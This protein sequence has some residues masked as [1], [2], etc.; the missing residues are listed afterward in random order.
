VVVESDIAPEVAFGG[1]AALA[2]IH[3]HHRTSEDLDF[4]LT[5]H[6]HRE[7]LTHAPWLV[8]VRNHEV[9]GYAYASRH[10]DPAAY[11]WSVNTSVYVRADQ[12]R[13]GAGRTLY[14]AL[15]NLLRVQGFYSAHAGIALPNA[16]SVGLH[17]AMGFEPIG[18]Y[19]GSGSRQASGV[20]WAG[21]SWRFGRASGFP[22]PRWRCKLRKRVRTGAQPC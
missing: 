17:E 7:V 5:R 14:R 12:K 20:T 13:T 3:L 11:Q 18:V 9:V 15:L 16:A 4:F 21:G 22:S 2:A 1:G 19:R 6:A 10:R 8:L